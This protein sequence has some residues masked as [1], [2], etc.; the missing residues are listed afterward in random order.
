MVRESAVYAYYNHKAV[1]MD[2]IH[3]EQRFKYACMR[4]VDN[5]A[6]G[7]VV[8]ERGFYRVTRAKRTSVL[9]KGDDLNAAEVE[10]GEI[11][12]AE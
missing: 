2:Y 7:Y 5:G 1:K 11:I 4:I 3:P 12:A 8:S 10:I 6:D 9:L